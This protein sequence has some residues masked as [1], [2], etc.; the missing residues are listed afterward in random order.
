MIKSA[1]TKPTQP[2]STHRRAA[3]LRDLDAETLRQV[4]GGDTASGLPTGKRMH[5]PFY[6]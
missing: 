2:V 5:K 1:S 6:P 4:A 3:D